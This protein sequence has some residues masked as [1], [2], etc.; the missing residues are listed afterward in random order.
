VKQGPERAGWGQGESDREETASTL[1]SLDKCRSFVLPWI[2]A[3]T[4]AGVMRGGERLSRA[5]V[6]N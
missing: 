5:A 2:S 4:V 6:A 1:Y 3:S